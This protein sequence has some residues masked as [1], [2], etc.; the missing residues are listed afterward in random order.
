MDRIFEF[1]QPSLKLKSNL[2]GNILFIN[3][4]I[5]SRYGIP[6]DKKDLE[7]SLT[8]TTEMLMVVR[9]CFVPFI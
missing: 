8:H 1:I 5:F 3:L 7:V 6:Q 9:I 4:L 2:P